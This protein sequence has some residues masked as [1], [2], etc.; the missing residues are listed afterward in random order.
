M[1]YYYSKSFKC[2]AVMTTYTSV[3]YCPSTRSYYYSRSFSCPPPPA[4]LGNITSYFYVAP[5]SVF[6]YRTDTKTY[7]STSYSVQFT[8][9]DTVTI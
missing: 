3:Q 7:Q 9:P 8:V 2:P 5:P 6:S 4:N 1:Q